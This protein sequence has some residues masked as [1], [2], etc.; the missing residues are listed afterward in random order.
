MDSSEPLYSSRIIDIFLKLLRKR[1]LHVNVGELL[2]Y[3]GMKAYEVADQGHWFTQEQVDRFHDRL[4]RLSGNEAIAREAGRFAASPDALGL[5]KQ[6]ILSFVGPAKTFELVN[7]TSA[8]LTR[9]SSMASRSIGPNKVELTATFREGVQ[10][11]PYQC[12]N[13]IGTFEAVL[14]MFNYGLPEIEHPECIFKGGNTCRYIVKWENNPAETLVTIRN[15]AAL[16]LVL[17]SAASLLLMPGNALNAILPTSAIVLLL[18]FL[19]E[20]REKKGLQSILQRLGEPTDKLLEQINSNY[21]NAQIT[22]E[23]GHAISRQTEIDGIIASVLQVLEARLG[24]DRG[25][26][27]LTNPAGTRLVFR[28]GFGQGEEQNELLRQADFELECST[29]AG[30]FVTS[31]R[32]RK[33]FLI[34]SIAEYEEL[35]PGSNRE[36]LGKLNAEAFLCCPIICDGESLGILAVDNLKSRKPLLQTDL[37]LLMG[38]APV[39]GVSIR[40]AEL[41]ETKEQQFNAIVQLERT[42]DELAAAKETSERYAEDL[43]LMN[44]EVRNFAYIVSHDLRAPLVNIKGFSAELRGA[45]KEVAPLIEKGKS[46]LS[47]KELRSLGEALDQDVPE[48]LEFIESSVNRMDSL[49]NAILKLSRLG[50]RDLKMERVD[51]VGIVQ[52]ILKTLGHQLE[53]GRVSVSVAVLP[54]VVSDKTAIEQIVGNL[55]DNALKYLDRSRAGQLEVSAESGAHETTFKFRD[56]GRGIAPEDMGKVFEIFRRAGKQDMPGE[57]MGLAY[58]KTLVR[59]LG[60]RIWCESEL[61]V[62]TLFCFTIPNHTGQPTAS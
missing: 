30:A 39:I 24:Y 12:E 25:V 47:D 20:H 41:L 1:Y 28:A 36:L 31:Y 22:N 57:G 32:E 17:V 40:N 60:G 6:N 11:K 55:L 48:A 10:E 56:N 50:R 58:V 26:I 35:F 59:R 29:G 2:S 34:N 61:G 44:E 52:S 18:A 54:E 14:M 19:A 49:I 15:Y 38:I 23:V 27:L 8:N 16:L 42:R 7:K 5:M 43:Q 62:G 9:S 4:V 45:L 33:P 46:G 51:V 13:R 53:V 21:S 3:A 37:N